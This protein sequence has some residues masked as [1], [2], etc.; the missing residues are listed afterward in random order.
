[1]EPETVH[2]PR[3]GEVFTNPRTG[4]RAVLLTDPEGH[5]DRTLVAHLFV[6]PGGR[7]AAPHVHPGS[8]ERFR[9]LAGQ[10]AFRVGGEDAVLGAGESAEVPPGTEHDWWQV[11][12]EE[13]Q[14]LVEVAPGDRF[15]RVVATTFGLARDGL[16]DA[17][18]L[19][20]LLQA[21]VTLRAYRDTIVFTSPPPRV[22]RV[23]FGA[24]APVGRLLGR[25]PVDPGYLFSREL[26]DVDPAALALL[27]ERGRLRREPG[28]ASDPTTA[29]GTD[30]RG[31]S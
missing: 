3:R 14:V 8:A 28:D 12:D 21:A 10:V 6:R 29:P 2:S 17:R 9:V 23:L 13:A 16:V 27:D 20:H 26:A 22:Q 25:Q 24:L 31:R 30:G 18:G 1:M 15:V 7:V 11:G 4:E 19:P 5:P